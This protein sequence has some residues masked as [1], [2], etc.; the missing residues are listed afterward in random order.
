MRLGVAL[1]TSTLRPPA[2]APRTATA[3]RIL[4]LAQAIEALGFAGIWVADSIGR[5]YPTLDPL[6][7]L[8]LLAAGTRRVELGTAILQ[9]PLRHP[10]EL[11][12]RI[13]TLDAVTGG[14]LRLGVGAGSTAA[15]FSL[16]GVDFERRFETLTR[17]LALM[18]LLWRGEPAGDAALSPWPG[19]EGGPPLLF[20]AWRSPRWIRHAAR[21]GAGWIASGLHSRWEDLEAG[22]KVY[23]E[24]GGRRAV[25]ANVPVE[26]RERPPA[27]GS[28]GPISLACPADEARERLRRIAALGFDDVLLLCPTDAPPD[29]PG[30]L[31]RIRALV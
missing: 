29:A 28:K 13:A 14:R 31:A 4:A 10:I 20:A 2:G 7:L 26:L 3:E 6:T 5:G 17:S 18:R 16:L 25:L 24:A 1:F 22:I 15:D 11:A 23:R 30:E 21:E 19:G 9:V 12:H 27:M 8:A